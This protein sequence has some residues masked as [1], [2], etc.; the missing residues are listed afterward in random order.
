MGFD[1][2]IQ[3][4]LYFFYILSVKLNLRVTNALPHRLLSLSYQP[5]DYCTNAE[6]D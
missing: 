3:F 1:S 6:P 2:H 5:D 4:T